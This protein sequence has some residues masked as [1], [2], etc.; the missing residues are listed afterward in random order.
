VSGCR[1]I[2]DR[3]SHHRFTGLC[4]AS[5]RIVS[6]FPQR[7]ASR[8]STTAAPVMRFLPAEPAAQKHLS[9]NSSPCP[10]QYA[11]ITIPSYGSNIPAVHRISD[12]GER[13]NRDPYRR[14]SQYFPEGRPLRTDRLF[15]NDLPR[16]YLTAGDTTY[17]LYTSRTSSI[18]TYA[19]EGCAHNQTEVSCIDPK[20]PCRNPLMPK[21]SQADISITP[22]DQLVAFTQ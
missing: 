11:V 4:T 10:E 20:M 21:D 1:N 8:Y 14:T 17:G 9:R 19:S 6:G 7:M 5:I 3:I 12:L 16:I 13:R 2:P 22:V 18:V 15:R